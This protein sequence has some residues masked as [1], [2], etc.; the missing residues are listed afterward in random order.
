VRLVAIDLPGIGKSICENPIATKAAIADSIEELSNSLKLQRVT[1]VGHDVGGQVAFS[2]LT[3]HS[4][5]L[6]G[7]VI[8]NVVVPGVDPWD[9]VERNP[10]I[11]HFRFHSIQQLPEL[12]VMGKQ[13][14]Y[15][16][17][18]YNAISSHPERIS[19]EARN[20]Y[21]QAYGT[22]ESLGA[23]FGW[24]RAFPQ[25]VKDNKEI[26]RKGTQINTP[27]LYLR[28]DGERGD[29]DAYVKGFNN[30]GITNVTGIIVADSGHFSS[31]ENPNAVWE[32]LE[33]FVGGL[34]K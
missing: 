27:L 24:Y 23:G 11:W 1:V 14:Q 12:L 16:D 7:A 34:T 9:E 3:R 10:Y 31:E 4:A 8:M 17:Y 22:T 33:A 32:Q 26:I 6:S 15:F 5:S 19:S 28:G 2:Y 30:A 18:F 21:A 29:I 20:G 25:D 13:R